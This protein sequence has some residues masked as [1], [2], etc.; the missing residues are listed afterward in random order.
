[1]N[2]QFSY[3]SILQTP[4]LTF[5]LYSIV[6][7]TLI[8]FII[9]FIP[10]SEPKS[11]LIAIA[12]QNG[13]ELDVKGRVYINLLPRPYLQVK[14]ISLRQKGKALLE[15]DD[16][17]VPLGISTILNGNISFS[18]LKFNNPLI[19]DASIIHNFS[20]I[21]QPQEKFI[22]TLSIKNG[23]MPSVLIE[24]INGYA[25]YG[26]EDIS[27]RFSFEL[28]NDHIDAQFNV[29]NKENSTSP[30]L[31][32]V[33]S[34]NGMKLDLQLSAKHA[35]N[36]DQLEGELNLF[37]P[38]LSLANRL[39]S[40]LSV[41]GKNYDIKDSNFQAKGIFN[42]S[43]A[44]IKL[45]D[46]SLNSNNISNAKI[47]AIIGF[48][49]FV[50]TDINIAIDNL[51]ILEFL[52][53]ESRE[54]GFLFTQQIISKL[55]T[56]P[57]FLMPERFSANIVVGINKI[58]FLSNSINNV[59]AIGDIWSRNVY[60]N[61]FSFKLTESSKLS[62]NGILSHNDI[63]PKFEGS[64]NFISS[65]PAELDTLT[66]R[67][68]ARF[69]NFSK[70]DLTTD[71]ILIPN[72][73]T[74]SALD[75]KMGEADASGDI[76]LLREPNGIITINS[77][78]TSN[79]IDLD[80]FNAKHYVEQAIYSFYRTDGDKTG[81]EHF[82][83]VN[84]Y[85]WLRNFSL[86]F[87]W[88][89]DLRLENWTYNKHKFSNM[90]IQSK[91]SRGLF[92]IKKLDLKSELIDM[93]ESSLQLLLQSFR[94]KINLNANIKYLDNKVW[95]LL[96]SN[97]SLK[98]TLL[99][100]INKLVMTQSENND[101][102]EQV[103]AAKKAVII[104]D[105][106]FFSINNYDGN[107]E[108]SAD[109]IMFADDEVNDLKTKINVSNGN[110]IF[111]K[112]EGSVFEGKFFFVGV[113]AIMSVVPN[114]AF[115]FS[116]EN[117]NPEPLFRHVTKMPERITG[118]VNIRGKAETI[119]NTWQEFFAKMSATA[120]FAGKKIIIT[121]F[122]IGEVVNAADAQLNIQNK[123]DN[124]QYYSV[125]GSSFFSD[126]KGAFSLQNGLLKINNM[127]L[128][129]NRVQGAFSVNYNIFSQAASGIAQFSFIPIKQKVTLSNTY[130]LAGTVNN[131]GVSVN[132]DAI[133]NYIKATTASSS[134][135]TPPDTIRYR[136]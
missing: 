76:F 16:I 83:A 21:E 60:L 39:L 74:F 135:N 32:K 67:A 59:K 5:S 114:A 7:I 130:A 22:E 66:N 2:E 118:Y 77:A 96:P 129:N 117:M 75:M 13:F 23:K 86:Y 88:M 61:E 3:K 46:L 85:K 12:S 73:L 54:D 93:Q 123:L 128:S 8:T 102:G 82:S 109:K 81:K 92:E 97:A 35:A 1:M 112:L 63:R 9:S 6:F 4:L 136:N 116:F 127:Q 45:N 56:P 115:D 30:S 10:L 119:G 17:I 100:D 126:I 87:N 53:A 79:G 47:N 134:P 110:I 133:I 36:V 121:G 51:N 70:I 20:Q 34:N 107:I 58:N 38:D 62:L 31:I 89:S 108:I 84:D 113:M 24:K 71:I 57:D 122:D 90:N 19:Y 52:P 98:A 26:Q 111:N 103:T 65:I 91:I 101:G 131:L 78:L 15:A 120:E 94:P 29:F 80:S 49:E 104:P 55:L 95:D 72:K 40:Q 14:Q 124:L 42:Y 106:N 41:E 44:Q 99:R 64:L 69:A 33:S 48:N 27:G 25:S 28:A 11:R 43:D 18:H 132:N 105:F 37:L 125:N 50:D 68:Q